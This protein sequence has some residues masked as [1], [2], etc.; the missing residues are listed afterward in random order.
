MGIIVIPHLSGLIPSDRFCSQW[1]RLS[2]YID[3]SVF[4]GWGGGGGG[5][6]EKEN[7]GGGGGGGGREGEKENG[8]VREKGRECMHGRIRGGRGQRF[9][10]FQKF[11]YANRM[12]LVHDCC[13]TGQG[14]CQWWSASKDSLA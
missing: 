11:V 8:G 2:L 1:K 6:G 13:V 7:G 5:G 14:D 9:R 3:P 10:S 4:H 12:C